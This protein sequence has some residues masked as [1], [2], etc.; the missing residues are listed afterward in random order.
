MLRQIAIL[1]LGAL[2]ALPTLVAAQPNAATDPS[3]WGVAVGFIPS[4]EISGGSSAIGKLAEVMFDRGDEGLDV[5]GSDFRIGIVRGRRLGGEWGVSYIRRSFDKDSTQGG[6]SEFCFT[7]DFNDV[8]FCN[9]SALSKYAAK[10]VTA[11]IL[12]R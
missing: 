11:A 1:C 10:A 8:T 3:R 2:L 5:K 12:L 9:T 7:N 4:F 6:T